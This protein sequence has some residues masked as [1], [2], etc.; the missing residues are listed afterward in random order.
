MP[1]ASPR[2]CLG[3]VADLL[4]LRHEVQ[5]AV[6]DVLEDVRNAVGPMEFHVALFLA[7][8]RLVPLGT[9]LLPQ[10]DEVHHHADVGARLDVEVAG[11]E[12]TA[13]VQAGNEFQGLVLCIGGRSLPVQVEMV[14]RR[15]SLQVSLL[16]G[17]AVPEAV[18]LVDRHVVHVDRHPDVARRHGDLVID[19][20]VD[21]EVPGLDVAVFQEIDAG[22]LQG[23]EIELGVVVLVE[24]APDFHGTGEGLL[25]GTVGSDLPDGGLGLHLVFLIQFDDGD[26]RLVG[27]ITHLG[28]AHVRLPDPARDGVRLHSP[29]D[30]LAG[31]AGRQDGPEDVPAV[32]GEHPAVVE[33]DFAVAGD[34]HHALR[35]VR[36]KE[37]LVAGGKRQGLDELAG[38]P[39]VIGPVALELAY[40]FLIR[41]H[42]GV[43]HGIPRETVGLAPAS[44][45]SASGT[46]LSR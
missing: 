18:G 12:V 22:L 7:D 31:L 30:D 29:G 9:E 42:L 32:L 5:D 45:A 3:H 44:P 4:G 43:A 23:G 27:D 24:L 11:V 34:L 33:L 13:H 20:R 2:W 39:V 37:E 35:V 26:L 16:E 14:R 17:L 15:G 25:R 8:E 40:F 28:E 41:T 46:G 38:A 21:D 1:A 6:L 19:S 36:R 10:G